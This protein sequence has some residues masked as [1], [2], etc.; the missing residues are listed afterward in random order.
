MFIIDKIPQRNNII[1]TRDGNNFE[2]FNFNQIYNSLF[3]NLIILNK[4][5]HFFCL[6]IPKEKYI[7]LI[8]CKPFIDVFNVPYSCLVLLDFFIFAYIKC[9]FK[10]KIVYC[11]PKS[12]ILVSECCPYALLFLRPKEICANLPSQLRFFRL[13][14]LFQLTICLI[15]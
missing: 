11:L 1:L 3:K 9:F 7:R 14:F 15:N 5:W 12:Q 13:D 10:F 8:R 4:V 6:Q 2:V